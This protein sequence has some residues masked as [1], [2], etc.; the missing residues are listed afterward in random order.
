MEGDDYGPLDKN[1]MEAGF[2][3]W[4]ECYGFCV[5]CGV[6]NGTNSSPS[7]S[8]QNEAM[9][10]RDKYPIRFLVWRTARKLG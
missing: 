8:V 9:R 7:I 10:L 1:A 3:S 4:L 6:L 5:E 2:T